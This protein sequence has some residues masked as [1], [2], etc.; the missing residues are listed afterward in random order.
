MVSNKSTIQECKLSP[1]FS[2]L[3][4]Y[5]YW[6]SFIS[7]K[8]G[9]VHTFLPFRSYSY[10]KGAWYKWNITKRLLQSSLS[11]SQFFY[12]LFIENCPLSETILSLE[13]PTFQDFIFIGVSLLVIVV[14]EIDKEII[15]HFKYWN[16]SKCLEN[17]V[18]RCS[19]RWAHAEDEKVH[20]R[21][22]HRR[23]VRQ[24][25][26]L[27]RLCSHQPHENDLCENQWICGG[28][29]IIIFSC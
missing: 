2:K 6:G 12:I 10:A 8:S 29:D 23:I 20:P 24:L 28:W 26:P 5:L 18:P 14:A 25:S 17:N 22:L 27:H 7:K 3:S 21:K 16:W 11:P 4:Y 13:E 19:D 9:L 1:H 15:F